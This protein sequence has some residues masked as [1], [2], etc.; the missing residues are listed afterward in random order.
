MVEGRA[1]MKTAAVEVGGRVAR[2]VVV[3][4]FGIEGG[5]DDCAWNES[6][7]IWRR[8]GRRRVF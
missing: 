3:V 5:I 4:A 8:A 1:A 6:T 2:E 7:K